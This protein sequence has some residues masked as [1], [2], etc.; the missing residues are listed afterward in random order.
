MRVSFVALGTEQLG[1]SQLSAIIKREGHSVNMAFSSQ[2]FNDRFNLQ[3]PAIAPFFDDTKN[4][5]D[6][7]KKQKPDV[8]AFGALTSTYQW[9]LAVARAAKEINPDTK[10]IF[11]GVHPSAVPDLVIARPEVDFVTVGEGDVAMP[12]I[13]R[14]ISSGDFSTP[15]VNTRFKTP[16]GRIVRGLQGAFIQDLDRLPFFDK[17]LW[18]DHVRLG[19]LYLTMASRGCPYRCTFCFNNFFANLPEEK[20][21]KYV[22]IRSV[23]HVMSEL[24]TAKKRYHLRW[25]DFQDD[26]FATNVKW[27]EE[28]AYRYKKEINLPYQILTHPR[29]MNEHAAKLLSNSGCQ[30]VQMGVQSMDEDFKK[31]SLMR[32]EKSDHVSNALQVM[33]KYGLKAKVDHM[34]GLPDEPLS[35]QETALAVYSTHYPKRIQTFWTCYLPGTD[36]MKDAIAKGTLTNEQAQR[37]NEGIDF[38]FFRNTD[39]IKEPE[40]VKLYKAYEVLFRL[41]PSIPLAFRIRLKPKHVLWIP[42]FLVRP[43]SVISDIVTGFT[44]G[45]PEFSA[46]AKHNLF[47]LL[48]FFLSGIYPKSLKA[49]R[50]RNKSIS[51]DSPPIK[52]E[53][54]KVDSIDEKVA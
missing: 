31:D 21:G 15:I 2:L 40:K 54:A 5:I 52:E 41:M 19:D 32:Y 50:I 18:E 16:D 22:R 45:N 25:I 38:F 14:Q 13:L 28:F 12:K 47:H 49:S 37:I 11:G 26:V 6:E 17:T 42:N 35:A 8:V 9:G 39:N 43:I 30:W 23:E 29:Y 4:V 24:R 51:L 53:V 7:L 44:Y 3:I 36:L 20:S 48:N 46:Y 34:F 1:I 27:L 33:H 10:V